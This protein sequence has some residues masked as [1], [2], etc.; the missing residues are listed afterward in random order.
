VFRLL[1]DLT[2]VLHVAFVVFVVFGGV[3]VV[4]WPKIAWAHLPAAAWGAWV[5]FAGWVCPLTPLENWLRTQ[6]GGA[7]FTSGFIEQYLIPLVYPAALSRELQYALGALVVLVN[8]VIYVF[9]LRRRA[10]A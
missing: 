2:V 4:R 7:A 8:A 6:G 1:A 9:V 10:R 5:E 3:L